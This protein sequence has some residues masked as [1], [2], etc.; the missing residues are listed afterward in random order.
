MICPYNS[1]KTTQNNAKPCKKN[2]T[3]RG[4]RSLSETREHEN[5]TGPNLPNSQ[6]TAAA[7]FSLLKQTSEKVQRTQSPSGDGM[8]GGMHSHMIGG[9]GGG[10]SGG[11]SGSSNRLE[12]A[13]QSLILM[14]Q[15]QGALQSQ[16]QKTLNDPSILSS[17]D[18]FGSVGGGSE[19]KFDV[20]ELAA[21]FLD[22]LQ[23]QTQQQ[24]QHVQEMRDRRMFLEKAVFDES[25]PEEEKVVAKWLRE[26]YLHSDPGIDQSWRGMYS[27]Y[28]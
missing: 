23:R 6:E 27:M 7:V 2:D 14:Q 17:H 22:V 26:T 21:K 24:N 28:C 13:R 19:I 20:Q 16:S 8:S 5:F 18:G 9:G 10:G 25:V 11:G 3:N 4:S 12:K 1:S 15:I